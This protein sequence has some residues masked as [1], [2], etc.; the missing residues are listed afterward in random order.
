M[1]ATLAGT[2]VGVR[3]GKALLTLA[4]PGYDAV[5]VQL[6][7]FQEYLGDLRDFW[8]HYFAPAFYRQLEDNIATEGGG[9]GGWAPLSPRYAAWKARVAPGRG[10]MVFSGALQRSL[11]WRGLGPGS[12]G[13]FV[14]ERQYVVIGTSVGYARW[15]QLGA[16][17]LPRRS[18]LFPGRNAAS[19]FGRLLHRYAVDMADAAGLQV[20][21]RHARSTGG[22]LL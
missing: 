1:A 4:V 5:V 17:R 10:L 20:A 7:R 8:T 18:V 21:S 6:S 11:T 2:G 22:G 16:D 12:G 9:V 14:P 3:N 15:H 19:T 13:I